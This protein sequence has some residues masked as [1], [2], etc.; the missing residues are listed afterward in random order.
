MSKIPGREKGRV[1][2]KGQVG[3]GVWLRDTYDLVIG[4]LAVVDDEF[5]GLSS[6]A[7]GLFGFLFVVARLARAYLD[8][9]LAPSGKATNDDVGSHC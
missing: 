3:A 9:H 8:V 4:R 5:V 7:D 1:E 2:E 6:L